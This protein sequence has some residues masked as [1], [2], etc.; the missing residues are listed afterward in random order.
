[1][2]IL[3]LNILM[4]AVIT[5][6]LLLT[7]CKDD[8]KEP[9]RLSVD[10]LHLQF[11]ARDAGEQTVIVETNDKD[12]SVEPSDDWI[13]VRQ[14][15]DQ[16]TVQ[17]EKFKVITAQRIGYITVKAGK[18][19][20]QT[21]SVTQYVDEKRTLSVEPKA[22]TFE[23]DETGTKVV[24]VT[25]NADLDDVGAVSSAAWLKVEVN[26]E[27]FT[28]TVT[29]DQVNT[30]TSPRVATITVTAGTADPIAFP[31]TQSAVP[32]NTLSIEPAS[33]TF[34]VDET[35]TKSVE[36]T[37]DAGAGNWDATTTAQWLT[38]DKDNLT[39]K[40]TVE[41][42]N[43]GATNRVASVRVTAGN[44]DAVTL[45][46]MQ[47]PSASPITYIEYDT[48]EGYYYGNYFK[49]GTANFILDFYNEESGGMVG[50]MIEGFSTL[51]SS[52]ADFKLDV[53]T[54]TIADNYAPK[55]FFKSDEN[56]DAYTMIYDFD[57]GSIIMI[58]GGTFEVELSGNIYTIT[59]D[60]TGEDF[61]TGET[62]TDLRYKFTGQINWEDESDD[63]GDDDV[64]YEDIEDSS[65]V[66]EG[67]LNTGTP[68]SF[69]GYLIQ[70]EYPFGQYYALTNWG[71]SGSE[72]NPFGTVVWL[73]Y[74]DGKIIIDGA[75]PVTGNATHTGYFRAGYVEAG[76][77][78]PFELDEPPYV[79]KYDKTNKVLD[80]TGTYN[81]Y[82]VYIGIAAYDDSTDEFA[83]WFNY[84]LYRNLKL[85]LT[86]L[87]PAP[88][89]ATIKSSK[90]L[91]NQLHKSSPNIKKVD[92]DRLKMQK[93]NLKELKTFDSKSMQPQRVKVK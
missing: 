20:K 49:S 79:V 56:L 21:V 73:E 22:L 61:F 24:Q 86:S 17:V 26:E 82:S 81:G 93:G 77:I 89:K 88:K 3:R 71:G 67:I 19:E 46:V 25:T 60:F 75:E 12:W 39:L 87:E 30:V 62:V 66:A 85:N 48:V 90:N 58:T 5:G 1:M 47:E 50:V 52:F 36:I 33:L 78:V 31:V 2:K 53:G 84:G 27:N 92:L 28:F 68:G 34:A 57:A 40:I 15:G 69:D 59:T 7:T 70:D 32:K 38:I 37:T 91:L 8:E 51:P 43:Y 23:H 6:A 65:Y 13:I 74:I 45:Q 44:A 72:A 76:Y 83:G 41:D 4:Y 55:T 14:S 9:D 10:Q 63:G 16:F 18:R 54:Y 29:V 80:F 64:D 11:F 35:G 42:L